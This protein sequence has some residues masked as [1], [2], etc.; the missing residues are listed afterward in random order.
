MKINKVKQFV[1]SS[2]SRFE[3]DNNAR[4]WGRNKAFHLYDKNNM[5]RGEYMFR[6]IHSNDYHGVK[7]SMSVTRIMSEKL[8]QQMQEIVYMQK[9]YVTLKSPETED[10]TKK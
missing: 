10:L 7:T 3:P 8:K 6:T 5:Y 1:Q 9:R 2:I 4:N